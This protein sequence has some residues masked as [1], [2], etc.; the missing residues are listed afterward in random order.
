ML[1][2]QVEERLKNEVLKIGGVAKKFTSPGTAGMPD[3][4]VILPGGRIVF[5]ETKRPKGGVVSGL[6]KHQHEK[7]RNLGCDVRLIYNY[8]MIDEFIKE[9][10]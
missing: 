3:R 8:R 6:Q 9:V 10:R 1:E 5:V 7:L 2:K 4:I